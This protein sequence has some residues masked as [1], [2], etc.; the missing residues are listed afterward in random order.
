MPVSL[1]I[2]SSSIDVVVF[3]VG[4]CVHCSTNGVAWLNF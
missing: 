3:N 4:S 1:N 2:V